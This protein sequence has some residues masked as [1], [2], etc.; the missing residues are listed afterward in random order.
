MG[1]CPGV[2]AQEALFNFIVAALHLGLRQPLFLRAL[3]VIVRQ[4]VDPGA[5]AEGGKQA[6]G[7]R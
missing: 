7:Q 3:L 6:W 4:T 5:R 2:V 1:R